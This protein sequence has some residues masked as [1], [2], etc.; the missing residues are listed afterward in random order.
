MEDLK[1]YFKDLKINNYFIIAVIFFLLFFPKNRFVKYEVHQIWFK[2]KTNV[3][4][5]YINNY[6]IQ[7]IGL[8]KKNYFIDNKTITFFDKKTLR[9]NRF[10]IPSGYLLS[11]GSGEKG[12]ILYSNDSDKIQFIDKNKGI[13]WDYQ[14]YSY[15]F[16]TLNPNIIFLI[17]GENGGYGVVDSTGNELIK[18]ESTGLFLTSFDISVNTNSILM[19]YSDGEVKLFTDELKELW[20]NKFS[21]STIQ[22][23]KKVALSS[24]GNYCAILSG[25]QKEYLYLINKKGKILSK[26]LTKEE[27]RRTIDLVF[28]RDEKYLAEESETG[29]RIYSVKNKEL[30]LSKTLFQKSPE[31]KMVTLD[32]SYDGK[33]ILV[34][35]KDNN[36]ICYLEIYDSKGILY[37]RFLFSDQIPYASFA[38]N[39]YNFLIENQNSISLYS[40]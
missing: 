36:N 14:T 16:F 21:D 12:A 18:P 1:N 25:L 4:R 19:G 15:P 34:V 7:S 28:S 27:R 31:R 6:Y 26:Y 32:I 40:L 23:I 10:L 37:H 11:C 3:N 24:K 8:L 2:D 35:Y 30:I 33:F 5:Q 22:I 38:F 17:T 13:T 39:N 9:Y 29:V 20:V